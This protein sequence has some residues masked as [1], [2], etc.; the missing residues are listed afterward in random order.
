MI[1]TLGVRAYYTHHRE[2]PYNMLP[3]IKLPSLPLVINVFGESSL[4]ATIVQNNLLHIPY[5]NFV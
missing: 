5:I 4:Y 1:C 2:H 3:L